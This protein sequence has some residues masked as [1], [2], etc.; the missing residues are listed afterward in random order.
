MTQTILIKA[1]RVAFNGG[2]FD[3]DYR[4]L[5]ET[6][7]DHE[8]TLLT[9]PSLEYQL[10]SSESFTWTV[11]WRFTVGA[12]NVAG[13]SQILTTIYGPPASVSNTPTDIAL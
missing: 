8:T 5:R 9:G 11:G 4:Y 6:S 2:Q 7:G 3:S 10:H 13:S 12:Y 1:D